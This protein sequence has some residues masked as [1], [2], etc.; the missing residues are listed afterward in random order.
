MKAIG[1]IIVF[2]FS[3]S[4]LAAD[5]E[6]FCESTI[7][8]IHDLNRN[9]CELLSFI[10]PDETEEETATRCSGT[11]ISKLLCI[12]QF[13]CPFPGG[14]EATALAVRGGNKL[15]CFYKCFETAS[16][17]AEYAFENGELSN[18][19]LVHTKYKN[20][21][22]TFVELYDA[23]SKDFEDSHP[24]LMTEI[25][26][27]SS[28]NPSGAKINELQVERF[29]HLFNLGLEPEAVDKIIA[30]YT[31]AGEAGE[32]NL[33]EQAAVYAVIKNRA[34]PL[35]AYRIPTENGNYQCRSNPT[36]WE[37]LAAKES[38]SPLVPN[39]CDKRYVFRSAT[40]NTKDTDT[41]QR[42]LDIGNESEKKKISQIL[43]NIEERNANF[44][45]ESNQTDTSYN[46]AFSALQTR[47]FS[48]W[49][50]DNFKAGKRVEDS[51]DGKD[52]KR[53]LFSNSG[54]EYSRSRARKKLLNAFK[55]IDEVESGSATVKFNNRPYTQYA[56]VT[57]YATPSTQKTWTNSKVATTA[58]VQTNGKKVCRT[59]RKHIFYRLRI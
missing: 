18:F 28:K 15:Q 1:I 32:E 59:I 43:D 19:E 50:Y 7:D 22:A 27:L 44:Q 56:S 6:T 17:R 37:R 57:H 23:I 25:A 21:E 13:N 47:Q 34:T 58:C 46:V 41:Y 5:G 35:P 2:L 4:L 11:R 9:S 45:N 14:Q 3:A 53:S 10:Y 33:Q 39:S 40:H 38:N 42:I 30:G 51:P 16:Q 12:N 20:G 49:N 8:N 55:V 36:K 31:L 52:L 24:E 48:F 54:T 26:S 29:A